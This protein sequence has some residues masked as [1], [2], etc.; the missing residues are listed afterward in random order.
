MR[1]TARKFLITTAALTA[2]LIPA[3]SSAATTHTRSH[4]SGPA[5]PVPPI[6]TQAAVINAEARAF[7]QLAGQGMKLKP[8]AQ[9]LPGIRSRL[10]APLATYEATVSSGPSSWIKG[11]PENRPDPGNNGDPLD[12][13]AVWSMSEL[14][15][16]EAQ[17]E[18]IPGLRTW[19]ERA[20][21]LIQH[22]CG[23]EM[24]KLHSVWLA[25]CDVY[26]PA[27]A[28]ATQQ[29]DARTVI[30]ALKR[31]DASGYKSPPPP[32]SILTAYE[33]F[34]A[35]VQTSN[36]VLFNYPTFLLGPHKQFQGWVPGE[37][38][39]PGGVSAPYRER[40]P[41]LAFAQAVT[42]TLRN[43]NRVWVRFAK[44]ISG[45]IKAAKIDVSNIS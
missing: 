9:T 10:F 37:P 36:P 44:R 30:N 6:Q 21:R 1:T 41:P 29:A 8:D 26:R 3:A 17:M 15:A 40:M 28:I 22:W 4:A 14:L 32:S 25:A 7:I 35:T 13:G 42:P 43:E 19:E 33:G 11:Y 31:G 38:N 23:V 27:S 16:G 2:L 18:Y 39:A 5:A 45:W 12:P 20:S 34:Y 24:R